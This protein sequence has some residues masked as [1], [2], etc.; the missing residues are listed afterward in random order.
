[1]NTKRK[2]ESQKEERPLTHPKEASGIFGDPGTS[3]GR[4]AV[5]IHRKI[6]IPRI[7]E[8]CRK[9]L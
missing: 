6:I 1:M 5:A 7:F 3:L 9:I 2:D 4:A 8:Y